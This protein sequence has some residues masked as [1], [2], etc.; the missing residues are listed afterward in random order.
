MEKIILISL[1]LNFSP[2]TLGFYGLY[3]VITIDRFEIVD[4]RTYWK[5][6]AS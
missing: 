1:K 6:L 4:S 3:G 2:D 5:S